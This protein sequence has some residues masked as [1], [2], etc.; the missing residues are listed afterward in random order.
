MIWPVCGR[1]KNVMF[2]NLFWTAYLCFPFHEIEYGCGNQRHLPYLPTN[3]EPVLITI[4]RTIQWTCPDF[5]YK[6]KRYKLTTP[7]MNTHIHIHVQHKRDEVQTKIWWKNRLKR[8]YTFSCVYIYMY[9][10][11]WWTE[12]GNN[13]YI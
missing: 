13:Y 11:G 8:S 6:L 1:Y 4:T 9:I 7:S 10:Y 2:T 3:D 5:T 12:R